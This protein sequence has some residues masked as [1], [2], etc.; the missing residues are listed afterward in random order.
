[1][2]EIPDMCLKRLEKHPVPM[3]RP[4]P[5]SRFGDIPD[6]DSRKAAETAQD[7]EKWKSLTH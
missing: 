6:L 7:S 3:Q 1:M 2:T 4:T 5:D